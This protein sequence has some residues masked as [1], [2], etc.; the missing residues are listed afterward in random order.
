VTNSEISAFL[1]KLRD[2]QVCPR[3]LGEEA[4]RTYCAALEDLPDEALAWAFAEAVRTMKFFP[5]PAE[6]RTLAHAAI[7]AEN[8]RLQ[9]ERERLQHTE[10]L[11]LRAKQDRRKEAETP[12]W[13]AK[14]SAA[15]Q[16]IFDA[17]TDAER[18]AAVAEVQ[19]LDD[20]LEAI[21]G[22]S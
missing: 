17:E 1:F 7:E 9:R 11:Q 10:Y 16:R 4:L 18:D 22:A 21:A 13:R 12:E 15:A 8:R 20:E 5:T 19:A 14:R 3:P 2:V 6:L